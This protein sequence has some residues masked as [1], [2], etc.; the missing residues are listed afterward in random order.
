[1]VARPHEMA[2]ELNLAGRR[3]VAHQD[4]RFPAERFLDRRWHEATVLPHPRELFRMQQQ[5]PEQRGKAV[6]S[7]VASGVEKLPQERDEDILGQSA[8]DVSAREDRDE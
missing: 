2:A 8:V 6:I 3:A 7:R 1:M 5:G 4:W